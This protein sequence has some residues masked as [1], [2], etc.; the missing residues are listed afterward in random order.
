M[1]EDRT[2]NNTAI[3]RLLKGGAKTKDLKLLLPYVIVYV[4]DVGSTGTQ[5]KF[6]HY[7]YKCR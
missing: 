2:G 4:P 1:E 5:R 7:T 3:Q 6:V